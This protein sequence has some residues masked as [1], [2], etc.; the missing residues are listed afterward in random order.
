MSRALVFFALVAL[1]FGCGSAGSPLGPGYAEGERDPDE[2]P[3]AKAPAPPPPIAES[4][5]G[6]PSM[7]APAGEAAFVA[8]TDPGEIP[9]LVLAKEG[10]PKLPLEHTHVSAAL[11]GFV[12]EVEVR[13]TFTNPHPEPIEAIY[14]FPLP[15][16]AAVHDM[17]MQIGER[18]IEA[19][20]KERR[21]A[22]RTYEAAK[23]EGYTSALLEQ[24]RPNVFTQSVAN[25]EPGKKIDVVIR[26]VQDLT[27]D[28]GA[29]EFVFPMVVGPRYSPPGRVPD[30]D[31]ISP[32]IVGK[33]ERTGHDVSIEV[34]ADAGS[35]IGDVEVP[36]HE[37][38]TRRPADGTLR[39]TLA[40]KKSLPNRD[41]LLRYR[42]AAEKPRATLYTTPENGDGAGYFSL[43]VQPPALDLEELVGRRELLFVVDVSG[44]MSGTPLAMCRRAMREA[45]TRLR[46]VDTF[47]IITFAGTPR[48]AFEA[49]RPANDANVREALAIVD[50]L[51]AGGGT[52]MRDAVA[53]ALSTEPGAGRHR[54]VFFLT[55][56]YVGN[57]EEIIASSDR[58]VKALEERG[59]RARV[60]G[61]GVGSSVNR[62]LIEGL[63]RAGK[64]VSVYATTREDPIRAVNRFYHYVD[65]AVMTDV[66][67]D[68]GALGAS[69]VFPAELPDLFA[70]HP[71]I[72]HGKYRGKPQA[73]VVTGKVGGREVVLPVQIAPARAVADPRR[74]FGALWARSKIGGLEQDLADGSA[75]ARQEITRLGIDHRLV[76]QFTSFVA[77]DR[78]RRVA[79]AG[80]PKS[81]TMPVEEAE[82]VDVD[83]AGGERAEVY[84]TGASAPPPEPSM[85]AADSREL[86]ACG[87]R[88]PGSQS[89]GG[90]AGALVALALFWLRRRK[91][92]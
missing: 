42:A 75:E 28:A 38:V 73:P 87:C 47:D 25:I 57:E 54:Y 74:V 29:Y 30:A 80:S 66:K 90:S 46:P 69:E 5:W 77:V 17:R 34:V 91:A 2:L 20:V 19:E 55:D 22:R 61:F 45:L 92:V 1:A 6:Q 18:V 44:S 65:R 31:R 37:V 9:E 68:W 58:F 14:I 86:R 89:G 32:P 21:E 49:P 67:V 43:V 23:A 8:H 16:N 79:A 41:F 63:S 88:V 7:A 36:T 70:S 50:E 83:M 40:E 52:E 76:T 51:H 81:I 82:G 13:Q 59:Q 85:A 12:A 27:Y 3:Y 15:E 72:V 62:Y 56:G 48:R 71:M 53:A 84:P 33:G 78:S 60:F 35:A 64:G 26:Y 10:R 11:T 4:G 24:E 39:L